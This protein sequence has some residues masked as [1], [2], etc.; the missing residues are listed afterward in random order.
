MTEPQTPNLMTTTA[1]S[2]LVSSM[3]PAE[4][5]AGRF[6]RAPDHGEDGGEGG[7]SEGDVNQGGQN[8]AGAE[9]ADASAE[10]EG[11]QEAAG[12]EEGDGSEEAGEEEG[13]KAEG[14]P[15][16]YELTPPEGFEIDDKLLAEADP[17]FRE[18]GLYSGGMVAARSASPASRPTC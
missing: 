18:P 5:A 17:I 2:A 3:T 1:L 13:E 6:M 9:G 15:E 16:K 8:E 12:A 4:R 7:G 10:G 14:P 11:E